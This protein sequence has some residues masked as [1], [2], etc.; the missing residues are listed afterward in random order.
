MIVTLP[1]G[2]NMAA[3]AVVSADRR[4]VRITCVPVFS[5]VSQVH[6]FNTTSGETTR[7][8]GEGTGG[9]GYSQLFGPNG[10]AQQNGQQ[11]LVAAWRRRGWRWRRQRVLGSAVRRRLHTIDTTRRAA[12]V[13]GGSPD[14]TERRRMPSGSRRSSTPGADH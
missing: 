4:Y 10:Q 11:P 9:Q 13:S 2:A 6:T 3:T 5:G 8:N 12:V 14:P 7:V 1:E